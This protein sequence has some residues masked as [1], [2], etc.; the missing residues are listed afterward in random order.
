MTA[1]S[2][3][4]D[5]LSSTIH[6]KTNKKP[7]RDRRTNRIKRPIPKLVFCALVVSAFPALILA[8]DVG[9][10][11]ARTQRSISDG[12]SALTQQL[13]QQLE[14]LLEQAGNNESLVSIARTLSDASVAA[15]RRGSAARYL[16][17]AAD[18]ALVTDLQPAEQLELLENI[19]NQFRSL[20]I[21]GQ[22]ISM[23]SEAVRLAES[24]GAA[25]RS[26][27]FLQEIAV[28][29]A[30]AGNLQESRR[31]YQI[32]LESLPEDGHQARAELHGQLLKL[33][34]RI[35]PLSI[36]EELENFER[37]IAEVSDAA[38]EANLKL[39][40]AGSLVSA[41]DVPLAEYTPVLEAYL[42][43]S[44]AQ[45]V[46]DGQATGYVL[47][48]FGTLRLRQNRFDEA[49]DLTRA[50]LRISAELGASNQLYR[51][52]WQLARIQAEQNEVNPA[53]S[54]YARAIT[55]LTD[56]QGQLLNGTLTT[57]QERV[58]PVYT[59]YINLLLTQAMAA[60]DESSQQNYLALV[61]ETLEAFN[62]SEI[63]DYFSDDCLLPTEF[64]ALDSV[65]DDTAVVYPIILP[66][67]L[68]LLVRLSSGLRLYP[69]DVNAESLSD[70]VLDYRDMLEFVS[71]GEDEMLQVAGQLYDW[72][73]RPYVSELTSLGVQKI[74]Y[75]T[76]ST[77]RP[78]PMS[79][80]HSGERYLVE[81][82]SIVTSLGLQLTDSQEN[83]DTE[84]TL[85]GGVSEA[86]FDFIAL[87]N[88][89]TE[90]AGIAAINSGETMLNQQFSL[91]AISNRLA[92]GNYS[93]VHLATHGYFD[94]DPS[95]S[96]I[97]TYDGTL[98]LN[99]LQE[100]V[101]VRRYADQP[102]DL[103]VLSACETAAGDERAVLGLAGVS[104][105]AGARSSLAS[106]WTISD[107][108]TSQ[109]MIAFYQALNS[110]NSKAD[111]LRIAQLQLL[112]EARF[113][114]PNF[115]SPYI[116]VGNWN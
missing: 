91:E 93:A 75:I 12:N 38:L 51:W 111:A 62:K 9:D 95:Q 37:H 106:L 86:V 116:L 74:V 13:S 83:L 108:A 94:R 69:V 112:A 29:E 27:S 5:L 113:Q 88:V 79:A 15:N 61:Q 101:G 50:A 85:L 65:A 18:N 7:S 3:R 68:M 78:I 32:A 82:F 2:R 103:L 14:P 73:A 23:L 28:L 56:I 36:R 102:L 35:D 4:P 87:D 19:S 33:A 52:Q 59:E 48:Y 80:L 107:E 41:L 89:G 54:N 42:A 71:V 97:L 46:D 96:F 31:N 45:L 10:L 20:G 39:E 57:F 60:V 70:A 98:N 58:T 34:V 55:T 17:V 6:L 43:F 76:A 72:I 84:T 40:I 30:E 8:Q 44:Q 67:Q 114:H 49:L 53:L 22:A 66:D 64:M 115:W 25:T 16:Q 1:I 105:K 11:V 90:I 92:V 100:T 47:G 21:R 81:E 110:G 109:L 24:T 63:L 26:V 77:L 104:L 99:S